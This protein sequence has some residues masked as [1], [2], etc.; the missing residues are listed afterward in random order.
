MT[1]NNKSWGLGVV[2]GVVLT[3]LIAI[4]LAR[5]TKEPTPPEMPQSIIEAYN[6]GLKDAVKTNPPSLVLEETCVGLW[7]NKQ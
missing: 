1:E 2:T 3:S 7:A 4:G 6:M 5:M